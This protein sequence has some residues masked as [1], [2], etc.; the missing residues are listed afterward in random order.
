MNLN[1]NKWNVILNEYQTD[2]IK[3][4]IIHADF[5]AVDMSIEI[6]V[7][8]R[9]Q[10]DGDAEGVKDGGV[11]Q[12]PLHE[13]SISAMPNNIPQAIRYRY[14]PTTGRRNCDDCRHFRKQRGDDSP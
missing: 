9:I 3:K 12:Q 13:L 7:N 8:V 6:Q 4:N 11:L 5:L 14:H 10:L 1:G 2:P